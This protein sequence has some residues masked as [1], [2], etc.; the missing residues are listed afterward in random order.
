MNPSTR[1]IKILIALAF[2]P[3]LLVPTYWTL[4]FLAPSDI[5]NF[6]PG[7][8]EYAAYVTFEQAFLLADGWLA[9]AALAGSIGLIMKRR[10]GLLCVLLAGSSAIYL[11]LMDLLYDLQHSVF[12]P[13]TVNAATEL[14]IV[15]L[16]LSLGITAIVLSWR[17]LRL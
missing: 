3:V 10:W 1:S 2:V 8:P 15:A 11:G 5:Q 9:L 4:W 16:S 7:S 12:V 17:A 14:A 13:L 6:Q